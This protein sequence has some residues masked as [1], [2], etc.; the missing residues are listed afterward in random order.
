MILRGDFDRALDALILMEFNEIDID[1]RAAAALVSARLYELA[2]KNETSVRLLERFLSRDSQG[3]S[4]EWARTIRKEQARLMLSRGEIAAAQVLAV[5]AEHSI[6]DV[7]KRADLYKPPL[8]KDPIVNGVASVLLPGLGQ[9]LQ[10]RPQD[11]LAAWLM[12]GIPLAFNVQARKK[13]EH[14]F[15]NAMGI[16]ASFFYL[17]NIASAYRIAEKEVNQMRSKKWSLIVNEIIPTSAG[18]AGKSI[19]LSLSVTRTLEN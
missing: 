5:E 8:N 12:I 2:G 17:G 6:S 18:K 11:A 9:T 13:G 1:N 4:I 10:G 19:G 15:A 3:L 7:P 14:T 16:L